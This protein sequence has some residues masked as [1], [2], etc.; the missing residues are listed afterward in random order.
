MCSKAFFPFHLSCRRMFCIWQCSSIPPNNWV[1]RVC[2]CQAAELERQLSPSRD[3]SQYALHAV[4][5][6]VDIVN[7]T[8]EALRVAEEA[9]QAATNAS[10][11]VRVGSIIDL[12][13]NIV[14][15]SPC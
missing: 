9:S 7:A 15:S 2:F 4:N 13:V 8:Q 6:F 12:N 11:M 5:A 3:E 1:F 10:D 14:F